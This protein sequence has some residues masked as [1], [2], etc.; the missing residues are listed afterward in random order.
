M[1]QFIYLLHFNCFTKT[2]CHFDLSL[3]IGEKIVLLTL[4]LE[5][6]C[7]HI[8]APKRKNP[9]LW[10]LVKNELGAVS[11]SLGPPL[12]RPCPTMTIAGL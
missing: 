8:S 10:V 2:I 6:Y 11:E 12:S 9:F 7:A 4:L 5:W 3:Y 1:L